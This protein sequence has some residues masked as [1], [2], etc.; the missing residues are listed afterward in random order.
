MLEQ[1]PHDVLAHLMT[2][3]ELS[4]VST[5]KGGFN[6]SKKESFVKK[7]MVLF[8]YPIDRCFQ[9]IYKITRVA[10]PSQVRAS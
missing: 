7:K 10:I 4:G 8:L 9:L 3:L 2:F 6:V 1:V 5:L